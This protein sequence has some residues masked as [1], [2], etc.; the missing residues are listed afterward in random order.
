MPF[1][2]LVF[3]FNTSD[4]TPAVKAQWQLHEEAACRLN[5]VHLLCL[6]LFH[7]PAD[8]KNSQEFSFLEVGAEFWPK[9]LQAGVQSG[10]DRT[11]G[12]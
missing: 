1:P 9:R 6:K 3:L 7:I 4:S 8:T 10:R 5:Q 11:G 12:F 2:A